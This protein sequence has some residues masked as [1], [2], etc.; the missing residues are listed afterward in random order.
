MKNEDNQQFVGNMVEGLAQLGTAISGSRISREDA[1]ALATELVNFEYHLAEV[2]GLKQ[3]TKET[4]EDSIAVLMQ[5]YD[6]ARVVWAAMDA[7][8]N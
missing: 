4:K 8:S 1:E 3:H 5:T 6:Q 7:Q 2:W